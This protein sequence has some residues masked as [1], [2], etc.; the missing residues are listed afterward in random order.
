MIAGVNRHEKGT[1]GLTD[2]RERKLWVRAV[3][4]PRHAPHIHRLGAVI[5]EFF[6]ELHKAE[7]FQKPNEPD[8][9]IGP[10]TRLSHDVVPSHGCSK[11]SS[12]RRS[13][14][15]FATRLEAS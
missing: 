7:L 10:R 1:C 3:K 8:Q 14:V 2:I 9:R 11:R 5:V 6:A 12:R 13:S 15:S 4:P